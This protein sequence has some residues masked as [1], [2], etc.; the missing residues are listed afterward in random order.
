[1]QMGRT[2]CCCSCDVLFSWAG[3]VVQLFGGTCCAVVQWD[4][5][6]RWGGHIV[7]VVVVVVV[8]LFSW[9][10]HVVQLL[11]GACYADGRRCATEHQK[12]PLFL[13]C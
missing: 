10:G 2:C 13:P 9:A 4:L 3:H 11:S 7:V 8:V 12:R 1:M 5:L 6:C